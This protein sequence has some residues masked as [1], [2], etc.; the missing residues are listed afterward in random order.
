MGKR[1]R[2]FGWSQ[3]QKCNLQQPKMKKEKE[4]FLNIDILEKSK[5]LCVEV[6][7]IMI[8]EDCIRRY[9]PKSK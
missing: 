5:N 6:K 4:K 8:C 7:K 9:L 1:R 3:I 2:G